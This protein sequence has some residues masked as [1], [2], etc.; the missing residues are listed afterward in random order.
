MRSAHDE[1][2]VVGQ[3]SNDSWWMCRRGTPAA[4]SAATTAAVMPSGP[5]T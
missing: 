4:R 5:Q 1:V 3:N 2:L